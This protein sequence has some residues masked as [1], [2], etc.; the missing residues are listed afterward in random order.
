MTDSIL[1]SMKLS[2][3]IPVEDESFD[4]ELVLHINTILEF[5]WQLG[6]AR[7]KYLKDSKTIKGKQ[8]TWTEIFESYKMVNMAKTYVHYKLKLIF[9]TPRSSYVIT[10]YEEACKTLEWRMIEQ[11]ECKDDRW[12][13]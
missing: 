4:V 2:L 10:A 8:E 6:V 1:D 9:D 3:G 7:N 12:D 5:L 11:M 13:H